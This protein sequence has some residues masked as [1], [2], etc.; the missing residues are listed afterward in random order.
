MK[1]IIPTKYSLDIVRRISEEME[2]QT[3]HH[4]YHILW[5]IRNSMEKEV[6]NYVEIGTHCG[7]S[8]SL[9]MK[10]VKNTNVYGIDDATSADKDIVFDNIEKFKLNHNNFEYFIGDSRDNEII[11]KVK[12]IKYGVDILFIDGGH[13]YQNVID[14]FLNYKDFVNSGG[15]IVFDDYND[16]EFCP[17]VMHAVNHIIDDMLFGEFDVLGYQ[18][19]SLGAHPKELKRYNEFVIYKK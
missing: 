18:M 13:S 16:F 6:V 9:M 2:G 19:N 12:N 17:Q 5:D 14:D 8:A 3:F 10:S 4:H 11:E 7:G 1:K 15:Y